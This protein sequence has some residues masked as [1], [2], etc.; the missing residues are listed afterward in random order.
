MIQ[1]PYNTS[2]RHW[3]YIYITTPVA[4]LRR[5]R[6]LVLEVGQ[7]VANESQ[8]QI[9]VKSSD[10]DNGYNKYV[11]AVIKT[12]EPHWNSS[13]DGLCSVIVDLPSI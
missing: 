9:M 12:N 3:L 11:I 6:I 8:F 10:A 7:R 2:H 5:K 13:F 1:C 4:K